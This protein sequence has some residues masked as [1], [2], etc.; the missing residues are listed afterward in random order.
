[1]LVSVPKPSDLWYVQAQQTGTRAPKN[2]YSSNHFFAVMKCRT[3]IHAD[4]LLMAAPVIGKTNQIHII[5]TKEFYNEGKLQTLLAFLSLSDNP[6]LPV[7]QEIYEACLR[8]TIHTKICPA[9][10]YVEPYLVCG[11]NFLTNPNIMGAVQLDI[12]LQGNN[13]HLSVRPVRV[14]LPP[15]TLKDLVKRKQNLTPVPGEFIYD[16]SMSGKKIFVLPRMTE[17][18]I[19][20]VSSKMPPSDDNSSYEKLREFWFNK[21]GYIL[22]ETEEGLFYVAVRFGYGSSMKPL[23]YPSLC[24]KQRPLIVVQPFDLDEVLKIF[25][26][27]L[28]QKLPGLCVTPAGFPSLRLNPAI[29]TLSCPNLS[30]HPQV[31]KNAEEKVEESLA[32]FEVGPSHS[33]ELQISEISDAAS[34]SSV[35][36]NLVHELQTGTSSAHSTPLVPMGSASNAPSIAYLQSSNAQITTLNPGLNHNHNQTPTMK[37]PAHFVHALLPSAEKKPKK[38]AVNDSID[39]KD[40]AQRGLLGQVN[41]PT[42]QYYLRKN[43]VIVQAKDR[44]PDLIAKIYRLLDKEKENQEVSNQ[45][46]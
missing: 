46:V 9:W 34:S 37:R 32:E 16:F 45:A 18:R 26:F 10:N 6:P 41:I 30:S 22:P 40:H 31:A 33:V 21:H 11:A 42:L 7:R 17:A 5:C 1:M 27:D 28:N 24:V 12:I 39:M 44:K 38:A 14:C 13:A 15:L 3:L 23:T 2:T 20:T 35:Y 25:A 43:G 4:P 36:N 29:E 19:E 8:Y